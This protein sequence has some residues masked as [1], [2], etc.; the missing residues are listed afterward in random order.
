MK[1]NNKKKGFTLVELLVVIAILAIL[2]SVSVVGYL[3][4]TNKA[5]QSKC[6]T[7]ALQVREVIN[8]TLMDG[9]VLDFKLDEKN[10]KVSIVDSTLKVVDVTNQAEENVTKLDNLDTAISTLF[11]DLAGLNKEG[12]TEFALEEG[13]L[14]YTTDGYKCVITFDGNPLKAE[15]VR[16]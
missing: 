10:Y 4:F 11:T 16:E 8:G 9:S 2:A 14:T 15:L 13:K 3:S 7:E 5:K 6:E 1:K 12:S